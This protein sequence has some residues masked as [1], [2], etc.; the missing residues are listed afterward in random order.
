MYLVLHM[1]F[2]ISVSIFAN[3]Y[4]F[5]VQVMVLMASLYA[6]LRE[7]HLTWIY[8]IDGSL[9]WESVNTITKANKAT[10]THEGRYSS[11]HGAWT[12][13]YLTGRLLVVFLHFDLEI[14]VYLMWRQQY[15]YDIICGIC[16]M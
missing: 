14:K 3:K 9:P 12:I 11:S 15:T 4:T 13:S 1:A 5:R 16:D 8:D 10:S 2:R 6:K 7:T